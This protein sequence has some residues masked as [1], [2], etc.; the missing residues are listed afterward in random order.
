MRRN[1]KG[2]VLRDNAKQFV[3]TN[4]FARIKSD[5]LYIHN[6]PVDLNE[7]VVIAYHEIGPDY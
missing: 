6:I 2:Q 1:R 4:F 3:I 5:F 7:G